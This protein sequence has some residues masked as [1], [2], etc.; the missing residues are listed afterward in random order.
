M[1]TVSGLEGRVSD[2]HNAGRRGNESVSQRFQSLLTVPPPLFKSEFY[3]IFQLLRSLLS[4]AILVCVSWIAS[5][6]RK[7]LG[8]W[9]QQIEH[10]S[11]EKS[12]GDIFA[13][14]Y[15]NTEFGAII[16][17]S[18]IHRAR[19]Y[20]IIRASTIEADQ[21][22]AP[23]ENLRL[24]CLCISGLCVYLANI[25]WRGCIFPKQAAAINSQL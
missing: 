16:A 2:I 17:T 4:P 15:S 14:L 18:L 10:L 19:L 22:T 12:G 5:P 9:Q 1:H 25:F 3:C 6:G 23:A 21:F 20:Q 8:L 7:S 11:G 24:L 13:C